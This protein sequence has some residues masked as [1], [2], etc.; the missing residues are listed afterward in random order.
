VVYGHRA[1][2]G[3]LPAAFPPD[4]IGGTRQRLNAYRRLAALSSDG[5]VD[6]FRNELVDRFGKLPEAAENLLK[7]TRLR[8]M[9][10]RT[11]YNSLVVADGK[12]LLQKNSGNIYRDHGKVPFIDYCN[13]LQLRMALLREIIRRAAVSGEE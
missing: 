5:D 9:T 2:E 12:V 3:F 4:Y 8:I 10:A 7:L 1:G 11:P 13:P 6:E